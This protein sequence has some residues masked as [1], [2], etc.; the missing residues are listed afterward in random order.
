MIQTCA[1]LYSSTYRRHHA[2]EEFEAINK[3]LLRI[4]FQ[5]TMGIFNPTVLFK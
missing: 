1:Y 4:Q 3:F 5:V 2:G